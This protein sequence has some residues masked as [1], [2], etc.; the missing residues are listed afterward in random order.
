[1]FRLRRAMLIGCAIL[2]CSA[3]AQVRDGT[4]KGYVLTHEHPTQG[5]AFGG[6]YAFAGAPGNYR[7]GIME[8]GYTAHC[9]GCSVVGKCDHGE[10]KG[11]IA[12]AT[13]GLGG[14]MG[15]HRSHMGPVHD[16]NSHL[17]YSTEWIKEAFASSD[18]AFRDSSM[19]IMV[20]FAVENEAMCEQLYYVN[21][22]NGGAGGDGFACS[23]GDSWASLKRQLDNLKAWAVENK[24]WM[25]IAYTADQ[26]R[27]IVQS[28]KLAIVLGIESEYAFG[29]EASKIDPVER[30]NKYHAEGVRTFYLAHKIN[31]RLSGA[32]LYMPRGSAPGR[33]LRAVQAMSGC[34]YYDD[35]VGHFPLEGRLGENLCD[36][37]NKCG[38]NALKGGKVTDKCN[39]RLG[40]VSE[41]N[42]LDYLSRG[43]GAFNGFNLY[44]LP[45]SFTREAVKLGEA[46]RGGTRLDA[47]DIERNNLGLSHDGE[48]VVRE[49][50]VKGMIVNIDHVSSRARKQMHELATEVFDGYPLNALHNKPN[51]RLSDEKGFERHEYDLDGAELDFVRTTGGFFGVRMGPTDSKNYPESG[52]KTKCPQT[53][54]ET[55]KMLAWLLDQGLSVGYSLDFATVTQGVHSRTL[56]SCGLELGVD[57][58][59]KY[60]RHD[61]EGLSHVGMMSRWHKELET[62]GMDSKYLDQLRNDGAEQFLRMWEKSEA[63]SR[64]GGQIP[65]MTFAAASVDRGCKE[66]S[67]CAGGEYCARMGADVRTNV[68]RDLKDRGSVCTDKRQCA[69]GRCAWGMCADPDECQEDKDCAG[70]EYCGDPIA[71][72]RSCKALLS[73]GKACTKADQCASARC[74]VF[75]CGAAHECQT[76][77]DCDAG[78]YCGDPVGGRQS[79]KT[80]KSKG[81]TCTKAEQCDTNRCSF[82]L[83]ADADEC[84]SNADCRSN[85]YCGDPI[86]GKRE[87][88]N[89]K[90]KG[91]ACTKAMQCASDKCS[92]F[93]CK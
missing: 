83:C 59:H 24:D 18:P 41:I 31:S 76:G 23:R 69:S 57:M 82:G 73:D 14:D 52:V 13:G 47:D 28:G 71:G 11:S 68:C 39:Y 22:G 61:A 48:R 63:K 20:A 17:R 37:T 46:S 34:F 19:R 55:A 81:Q 33:A 6:N 60:G 3:H 78:E 92:L 44:P 15:N 88:K 66:D 21:K 27:K 49:A 75:V 42:Y 93:K 53:S 79:C 12:A 38:P 87:C 65:R 89:L 58:I 29:S 86:S 7:N 2:W 35:N 36:N 70:T 77:K 8:K 85:Q 4:T 74:T 10:V 72:K 56:R 50:M 62:I 90:G 84:R 64:T 32:D 16:S 54:T 26:A 43:A 67:D 30:L 25:Q 80:Q 51:E 5:M 45:P 1:M 40:E 9:G 91:E